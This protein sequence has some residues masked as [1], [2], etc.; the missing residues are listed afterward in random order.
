VCVAITS[1][2]QLLL[3]REAV[4]VW[5]KRGFISVKRSGN[6]IPFTCSVLISEQTA[7]ISLHSINW[8]GYI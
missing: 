2:T 6:E 1:N 8:S 5:T 7:M 4:T 3:N